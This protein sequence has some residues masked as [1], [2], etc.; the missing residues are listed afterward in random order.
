MVELI[1]K[2]EA[3]KIGIKMNKQQVTIIDTNTLQFM[4]VTFSKLEI[5]STLAKFVWKFEIDGV[6]YLERNRADVCAVIRKALNA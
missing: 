5:K 4:G 1:H 3:R 6:V 2:A